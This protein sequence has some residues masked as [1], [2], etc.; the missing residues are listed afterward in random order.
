MNMTNMLCPCYYLLYQCNS[1]SSQTSGLLG[2][3]SEWCNVNMEFSQNVT[4]I[5]E[6]AGPVRVRVRAAG[7]NN[8]SI[9]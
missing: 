2:F 9:T 1:F 8:K 5:F 7:I 6:S 3:T 4:N